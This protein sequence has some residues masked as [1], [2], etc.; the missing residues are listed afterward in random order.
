M[1]VAI[2]IPMDDHHAKDHVVRV[3]RPSG[4]AENDYRLVSWPEL[5]R[6]VP[7]FPAQVAMEVQA[8]VENDTAAGH[9]R[10]T[11]VTRSEI[12]VLRIRR[13]IA[14]GAAL[15]AAVYC[16]SASGQE[17]HGIAANGEVESWPDGLF[18]EAFRE[19]TAICRAMRR[20]DP[21]A[22]DREEAT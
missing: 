6:D 15:T 13:M 20:A 18:S 22:L 12:V 10:L 5:S 2:M 9:P 3:L 1:E 8:E 21:T 16:V 19:V 17:R 14:E 7:L 11:I 4:W